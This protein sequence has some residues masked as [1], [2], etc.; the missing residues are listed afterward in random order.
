MS[1]R[2]CATTGETWEA[3][4]ARVGRAFE[5]VGITEEDISRAKER[6]DTYFDVELAGVPAA[7]LGA[8]G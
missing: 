2:A 3:E 1:S 7:G 8:D 4:A 6:I 5:M